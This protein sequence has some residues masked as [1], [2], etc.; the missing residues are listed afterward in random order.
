MYASR[1]LIV[2]VNWLGD[3]LFSTPFIRVV[4]NNFPDAFIACVVA[5]GIKAALEGNPN[6]NEIIIY[7]EKGADKGI[8]AKVNF[9]K[10]LKNYNFD[11]VFFLH[12]S[13]TR[14][15]L[16]RLAGIKNRIGYY[17]FKRGF[18]LTQA[19]KPPKINSLH[20]VKFYLGILEAIGLETDN[21]GCDFF[22]GEEDLKWAGNFV[23]AERFVVFNPGGNWLPKRWPVDNFM[24]LGRLLLEKFNGKIRIVITGAS[25]DARLAENINQALGGRA[26]SARGKA[27]LKQ[28]AAIF[29][30]SGLVISGDSGPLHIAVA[31]GA[32]A[33][34]IFG[35]TSPFITGPY[36]ADGKKTIILYKKNDCNIPCYNDTC[37][38]FKCMS[39]ITP[40]EVFKSAEE[41][42]K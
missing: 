8:F 23:K 42:L 38:N 21:K 9:I 22:I 20:R 11:T 17:T 41:F 19:L 35:P 7:D 5:P 27:S 39:N 6:V 24:A 2:E 30:K 32:N 3:V 34:G 26:I 4:R 25:K 40:E 10:K 31:V 28:T 37:D 12:R 14:A 1:I 16:T 36:G 18:L 13:F 15:L 33:I 29:K